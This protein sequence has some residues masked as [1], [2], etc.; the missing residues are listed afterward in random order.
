MLYITL[1]PTFFIILY[2][3]AFYHSGYLDNLNQLKI[4]LSIIEKETELVVEMRNNLS[5]TI[6]R[7]E[8]ADTVSE[9][10]EK[11]ETCINSG[12]YY[13]YEGKSGYIKICKILNYNLE[14]NGS[15]LEFGLTDNNEDYFIRIVLPKTIMVDKESA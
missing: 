3:N 6:D 4:G 14:C 7:T 2:T 1:N 11:L 9:I 13:N 12:E 5:E 10:Q 8:L 15:Y